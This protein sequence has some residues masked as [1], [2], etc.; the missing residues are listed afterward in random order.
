MVT[1]EINEKTVV[2]ANPYEKGEVWINK[3]S[4]TVVMCSN[5]QR[6]FSGTFCGFCIASN[7]PKLVG[8][9]SQYWHKD[10][11]IPFVGEVKIKSE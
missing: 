1:T 8:T 11:F 5:E 10:E 6:D 2:P 9:F 3:I 4:N 7:E